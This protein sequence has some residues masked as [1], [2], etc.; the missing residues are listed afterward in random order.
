MDYRIQ[1]IQKYFSKVQFQILDENDLPVGQIFHQSTTT[2]ITLMKE[3]QDLHL[4]VEYL[5]DFQA[6]RTNPYKNITKFPYDSYAFS[7]D[8]GEGRLFTRCIRHFL[9]ASFFSTL[10]YGNE[11]FEARGGGHDEKG[12]LSL[13]LR[14]DGTQVGSIYKEFKV[15]NDVHNFTLSLEDDRY[16]P[17]GVLLVVHRYLAS[18]YNA[19]QTIK[20]ESNF[21]PFEKSKDK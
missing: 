14:G 9:E 21:I 3:P 5:R 13:I 8:L 7:G 18:Y 16:L 2:E 17:E 10:C 19:E 15:I 1:Q 6:R 4:F 12:T 20:S 11:V